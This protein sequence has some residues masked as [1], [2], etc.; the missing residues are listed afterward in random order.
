MKLTPS[1][2]EWKDTSR[3]PELIVNENSIFDI[4]KN[5]N[6]VWGSLWNEWQI[7]WT[8]TP[9]YTLN[10]STNTTGT[11]FASDPNLVIK[12]K[13]RTRSRN[14]T[15]NRLSPYGAS[16]TDSGKEQ[17]LHHICP[18]IRS[19]LVKFVAKG[20]EPDTQLY[21]FFDGIEVSSWVN[22]D[23]VTN[24]T[25]PFTGRSWLC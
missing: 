16:S 20:L 18:Y 23:D 14:G 10:N 7:S 12:G 5:N 21:A 24:I 19:K 22:P 25:T 6:N 2:D 13:T 4:I 1:I 17:Y 3:M 11:Q 9:T 8:G 15:Q